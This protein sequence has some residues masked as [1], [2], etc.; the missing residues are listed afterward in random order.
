MR[1]ECARDRGET[2]LL[3]CRHAIFEKCWE[4]GKGAYGVTS[5]LA[6]VSRDGDNRASS[7]LRAGGHVHPSA[8][9]VSTEDNVIRHVPI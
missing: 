9:D 4:S 8:V 7:V 2:S 3:V 6:G 1:A 5:E